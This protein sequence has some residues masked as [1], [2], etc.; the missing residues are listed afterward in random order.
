MIFSLKERTLNIQDGNKDD[1]GV[2]NI[3]I[4]ASSNGKFMI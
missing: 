2:G 3:K 4:D 1:S